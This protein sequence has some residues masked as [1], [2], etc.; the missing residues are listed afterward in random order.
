M[1]KV[2]SYLPIVAVVVLILT[3]SYIGGIEDNKKTAETGTSYGQ[4]ISDLYIK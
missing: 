3:V 1:K 4:Q 2:I